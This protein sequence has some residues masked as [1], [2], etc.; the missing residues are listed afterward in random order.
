[1]DTRDWHIMWGV[2]PKY[3]N[4][5]NGALDNNATLAANVFH[6]F[7]LN[8][9][10]QRLMPFYRLRQS[11]ESTTLL[12]KATHIDIAVAMTLWILADHSQLGVVARMTTKVMINSD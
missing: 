5:S 7:T 8:V 11:G 1:M 2:P 9:I 6:A 10:L 12:L 3:D 4:E